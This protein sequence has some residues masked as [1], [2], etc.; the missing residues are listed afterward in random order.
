MALDLLSLREVLLFIFD[1]GVDI[2]KGATK[3][4]PKCENACFDDTPRNPSE[5]QN[6]NTNKSKVIIVLGV[7]WRV[8]EYRQIDNC[9]LSFYLR[10]LIP[11][12]LFW[13]IYLYS[14]LVLLLTSTLQPSGTKN[15]WRHLLLDAG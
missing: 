13:C 14:V 8:K 12:D 10:R 3:A 7:F 4:L 11:L 1:V 6:D 2:K 5:D 15:G 9:Q